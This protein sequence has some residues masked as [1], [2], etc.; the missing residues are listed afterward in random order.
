MAEVGQHPFLNVNGG[1]EGF[2]TPD[3]VLTALEMFN[4]GA[5]ADVPV[6]YADQKGT[7]VELITQCRIEHLTR[8]WPKGFIGQVMGIAA[9]SVGQSSPES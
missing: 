8:N 1:S 3:S 2:P 5:L 9:Q 7:M 6:E 4:L